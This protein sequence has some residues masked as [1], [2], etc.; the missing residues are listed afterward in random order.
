MHASLTDSIGRTRFSEVPVTDYLGDHDGIVILAL[1]GPQQAIRAVW[2]NVVKNR[3]ERSATPTE[4]ILFR[5]MKK[6]VLKVDPTNRYHMV[7]LNDW[8]ALAVLREDVNRIQAKYILGGSEES[9]SPWFPNALK[10]LDK[11]PYKTEWLPTIWQ[12]AIESNLIKEQTT[13]QSAI[14]IWRI[15]PHSLPAWV[16]LWKGMI[17]KGLV[18]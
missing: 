14:P 5:G 10:K 6:E 2:A 16:K 18:N 12:Q 9:P 13:A 3:R 17:Q 1:Q 11:L 4:V 7:T 15:Y 8:D